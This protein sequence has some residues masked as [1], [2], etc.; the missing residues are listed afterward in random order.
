MHACR[1]VESDA[2][3]VDSAASSSISAQHIQRLYTSVLVLERK[4][5]AYTKTRLTVTT[6]S[7]AE[8]APKSLLRFRDTIIFVSLLQLL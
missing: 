3:A 4:R 2:E 5:D 7:Y 1:S 6:D 8:V